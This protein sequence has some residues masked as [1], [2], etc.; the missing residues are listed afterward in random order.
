MLLA[1]DI[2][3]TNTVLGL[4][5]MPAAADPAPPALLAH[6]RVTTTRHLTI[7]EVGIVLRDLFALRGLDLAQVS[8]VVVSS[9]V[10]PLDTT[11]RRAVELY[12]NVKPIF[13][14]P[15]TRTG[16]PILTD[17]PAEVGADRIVNCIAAIELARSGALP[18]A[19]GHADQVTGADPPLIVVDFGTAT[20]FDCIS[21]RGEFVGGAIA[22]GL[23]ISAEALFARTARLPRIDIRKPAKVVGTGTVDN[24]QIGLYYGYI[25]LVD[26]ILERMIAEMGPDTRTIATGG[27]A[28]LI[29]GGSRYISHV[30]EFLTLTGLRLVYERN[31][32]LR[33]PKP[34]KPRP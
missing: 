14:E 18:P 4:Y 27:L 12:C 8:G 5:R 7:D 23:G 20:T 17:N 16:L 13:V 34:A 11:V 30:D 31:Q 3:N 24:I 26:G 29:A 15:G 1:L 9:V 28:S 10:P 22:P 2:G 19:G 33:H 32:E 21:R 25:G 6:W